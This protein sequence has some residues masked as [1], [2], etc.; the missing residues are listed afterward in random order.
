MSTILLLSGKRLTQPINQSPNYRKPTMSLTA[1]KMSTTY[2]Y[3]VAI[4]AREG[5]KSSI[6]TD[7]RLTSRRM[8]SDPEN[9]IN[10]VLNCELQDEHHYE[11]ANGE[12][13]DTT[14]D[15]VPTLSHH[16]ATWDFVNIFA[17]DDADRVSMFFDVCRFELK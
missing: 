13:L 10:S 9:A 7:W 14:G 2:V 11:D 5:R 3:S 15:H 1:P 17:V 4:Y 6:P 12:W 16:L 8:F